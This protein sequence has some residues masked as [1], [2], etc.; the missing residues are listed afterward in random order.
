MERELLFLAVFL[1]LFISEH[2]NNTAHGYTQPSQPLPVFTSSA[3]VSGDLARVTRLEQ[4]EAKTPPSGHGSQHLSPSLFR[5]SECNWADRHSCLQ[6]LA[7]LC[8]L[9]EAAWKC[10][11]TSKRF[12]GC[13]FLWKMTLELKTN[14]SFCVFTDEVRWP[15]QTS[16]MGRGS[17]SSVNIFIQCTQ[18]MAANLLTIHLIL[19]ITSDKVSSQ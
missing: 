13:V 15:A 8:L 17:S 3:T 18:N 11:K 6:S 2:P 12:K 19:W 1:L 14:Y 4:K 10:L 7:S 5:E 9:F 16:R